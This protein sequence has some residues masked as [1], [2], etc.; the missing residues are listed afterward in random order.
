MLNPSAP[1][2]PA[3]VAHPTGLLHTL[4]TMSLT[5]VAV[6]RPLYEAETAVIRDFAWVHLNPAGQQMLQQ[7]AVPAASLLTLFP[8]AQADGVFAKC[9]QAFETGELQ[10]NQTYY[11]ADGLDGY[12]VLVAQRYE[13]LLVVNFTDTANFPR[14]DAEE[15]LRQSQAREQQARAA[16]ERERADLVRVFEQ[17]SVA[18]GLFR[19]PHHLVEL[20]NEEIGHILNRPAAQLVGHPIFDAAPDLREQGLEALMDS[21]FREGTPHD[22]RAV[23]VLIARTGSQR[24]TQGYFNIIYRPQ[25]DEHGQRSGVVCLATEVTD[26]VLARQQVDQLNQELEA[27]VQERAAQ[28]AEQQNLLHQILRQL[29]AFVATLSGPEHRFSFANDLYQQ[30]VA[31]RATLGASVAEALPE[32]VEQGFIQVL[33]QVYA[34]GQP[35]LGREV[36]VI[37]HPPGQP[38]AQH[39]LDLTY[40]PLTDGQ[41][42]VQGILVFAVDVTAQVRT[43]RQAETLQAAMLAVAQRKAQERQD[44]YQVFEQ[45]PVAVVLLREPDHRIDYFNPAFTELFPPEP[46]HD[47]QRGLTLPQAYPQLQLASLVQLLDRVFRTGEPQV[48]LDMPLADWQP[49]SPRFVTFSYQPYREEGRIAGVAAFLY[50]VTEQVLT[51]RRVEEAATE[52]RLLT[53]HASAFL[54]RTDAA[55]HLVYLNDS[56]FA[57]TGLE[58][59]ALA[60]LDEAWAAVH[61]DDLAVQ[62][63]RFAA[64]VAAG[65]PWQSTPYRFRRHDGH[66]RW[67]LSRSQPIAGA[68]GQLSGSAGLTFDVHEQVE[69]QRQLERTN[70]DLDT[71]VY[72]A[73]H[74]LKAPIANIEGLLDVLSEY[75][76]PD[77]QE[78]MVPQLMKRVRGAIA[79]FQQTVGHL[80]DVSYL[81]PQTGPAPEEVDVARIIEDVRQDLL[82]LL[83]GTQARLLLEVADCPP[84]RF[85]AKDLRSIVYNLLS[86]AVKYRAPDRAP[87]VHLRTRCTAHQLV[88]EVQDNGLGLDAAQQ[89]KLFQMFKRLHTHVEGSGVGLYMIKRLIENAGGTIAVQSQLGV[90]STFTVTLPQAGYNAL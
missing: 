13:N 89:G 83:E 27:R 71:F 63:P 17:A 41:G 2:L 23:P 64:A 1:G 68:D 46:G 26:Q 56:F 48:V 4:L 87:V 88:L 49:G 18:I 29:P 37:L 50:D 72:T 67:M 35:Y 80:T 38:T 69:L 11:R 44:L 66:Y 12:F 15:A 86:N 24:P 75:L 61:P 32:V 45:A 51:R 81:Q 90:G 53:A 5:A 16:A 25:Y 28:L 6:L 7:P 9:C 59:S 82:P 3:D 74:D 77:D 40:Q 84:V 60:T 14:T 57:W 22:L 58:A 55:G 42:R 20:A 85:A 47:V 36:A 65:Q 31:G 8:T 52:L 30:L 10:R 78:P 73:S 62:Q 39:Y 76:P 19:G 33:D 34:T 21:T 43:R 54:F 70:A 79:R